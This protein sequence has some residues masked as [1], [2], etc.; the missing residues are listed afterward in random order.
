MYAGII[1]VSVLGYLLNRL[2]L[3]AEG[4]AMRWRHGMSAREAA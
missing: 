4:K 3:L 1:I 2:F